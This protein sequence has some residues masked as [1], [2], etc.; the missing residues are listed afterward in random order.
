[1][2][3]TVSDTVGVHSV[4]HREKNVNKK[5]GQNNG[6]ERITSSNDRSNESKR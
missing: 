6:I 4:R 5:G 2:A 1:M 3:F